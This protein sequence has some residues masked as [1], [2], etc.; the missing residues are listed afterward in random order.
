[1]LYYYPIHLE[2]YEKVKDELN[3]MVLEPQGDLCIPWWPRTSEVGAIINEEIISKGFGDGITGILGFKRRNFCYP[4]QLNPDPRTIQGVHLDLTADHVTPCDASIVFPLSG[5]RETYMYFLDGD[6]QYDNERTPT[7]SGFSRIKWIGEPR[8]VDRVEIHDQ[9]YLCRVST[10][11][12]ASSR[13]DGS[14]RA[15]ATFRI[16]GNPS[17]EEIL[18]ILN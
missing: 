7:G 6:Y 4:D 12:A 17:F 16:R 14:F 11:H 1:M 10:P 13:T 2:C 18:N 8:V 3:R 15:V 9:P 5:C